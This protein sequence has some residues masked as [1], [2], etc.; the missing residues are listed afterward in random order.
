MRK[1]SLIIIVSSIVTVV[2]GAAILA[3][4]NI[5]H[6]EPVRE[7]NENQREEFRTEIEEKKH[8]IQT[9]ITS[10]PVYYE[11]ELFFDMDARIP[12]GQDNGIRE[13]LNS[14]P[15]GTGG[16]MESLPDGA[17]RERADK[18]LYIMYDS[19]THYRL[20]YYFIADNNYSNPVGFPVVIKQI[21][22]YSDFSTLQVGDSITKVEEIDDVASLV[23]RWAIDYRKMNSTAVINELN[24]GY[25]I[26]SIHYLEDGIL[27]ISY[28][29]EDEGELIVASIDYFSDYKMKDCLGRTI[30]YRIQDSDLPL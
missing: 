29:M 5:R 21:H 16:L 20:Y 1:K 11:E 8:D 24:A 4:T 7:E 22:N 17:I 13:S 19:D 23:R 3:D 10:I 25:P 26:T 2:A 30:N 27:K 15:N 9:E 28:T 18:S 12:L 14:R 6:R